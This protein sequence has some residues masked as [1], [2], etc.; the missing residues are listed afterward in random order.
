VTEIST[1]KRGTPPASIVALSGDVHHAYL[2][3]VALP[4]GEHAR[5]PIYQAVCSPIR[6]PLSARERTMIK[7]AAS[8]PAELLTRALARAAGVKDPPIRWRLTDRPK[9]DNQISTLEWKGRDANV[10]LERAVPGDEEDPRLELS[11]ERNLT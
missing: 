11:A 6:N 2:A 9:F 1:G 10:K 7:L 5:T 3:E 8:K 4:R